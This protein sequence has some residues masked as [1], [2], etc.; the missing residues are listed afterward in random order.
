MEKG[1]SINILI[2]KYSNGTLKPAEEEQL[3]LWLNESALN[4]DLFRERLNE[5]VPEVKDQVRFNSAL[6]KTKSRLF[7]EQKSSRKIQFKGKFRRWIELAAVLVLGILIKVSVD[8]FGAANLDNENQLCKI[9]A[10]IGQKSQVMLPDGSKVWLNSESV[11]E[12]NNNFASN[13]V[14]KLEGEAY[15][16]VEKDK[17]HAF[18]V[19]TKSYN[20]VVHGTRFNVMAYDD[21]GYTQTTLVEGSVEIQRGK[22]QLF[23]EPGE[24]INLQNGQFIERKVN[25]DI[26]IAWKDNKFRFDSVKFSELIRRLERWYDVDIEISNSA[27]LEQEFSGVFKNDE[28]IFQVLTALKYYVGF[29]YKHEGF[30]KI[31]IK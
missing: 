19:Q 7:K 13:R 18:Q 30:R 4:R 16:E 1:N 11:I 23:L 25:T 29:E 8:Y 12:F 2:Q 15:F 3:Y 26:A 21:L 14:V 6:A 9:A 20:V 24:Q 27:L 10:P 5:T 22:Q 31:T 28:T 17:D